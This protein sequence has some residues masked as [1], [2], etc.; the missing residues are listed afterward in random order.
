MEPST[1]GFIGALFIS[2][3]GNMVQLTINRSKPVPLN[4]SLTS[5]IDARVAL[6]TVSCP[7]LRTIL[8]TL[9]EM[10]EDMKEHL[11]EHRDNAER[12]REQWHDPVQ[13]G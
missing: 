11:K 10:R 9:S 7:N 2:L 5:I 12:N 4:G 1:I 13:K 6:H 3:T 8:D